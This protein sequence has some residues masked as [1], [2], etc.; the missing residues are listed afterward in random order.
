MDEVARRMPQAR[1]VPGGERRDKVGRAVDALDRV[2]KGKRRR[3]R[4][5]RF[6]RHRLDRRRDDDKRDVARAPRSGANPRRSP[7]PG[8]TRRRRIPPGCSRPHCRDAPRSPT[9]GRQRRR[10]RQAPWRASSPASD[11]GN[12]G[13]ARAE[14]R[15]PAEHL[16]RSGS[17]SPRPAAPAPAQ[18]RPRPPRTI[19][20]A[21]PSAGRSGTGAAPRS[22]VTVTRL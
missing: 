11:A 5:A 15:A 12:D 1:E 2:K 22:R 10:P 16:P 14:A 8:P 7:S 20:W 9:R 4:A 13:D 3:Q 17:G 21:R 19:A 6:L 18:M